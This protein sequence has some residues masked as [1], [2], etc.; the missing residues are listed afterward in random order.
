MTL[1]HFYS[2]YNNLIDGVVLVVF[3]LWFVRLKMKEK[4]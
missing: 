4:L 3:V 1:W 2:L